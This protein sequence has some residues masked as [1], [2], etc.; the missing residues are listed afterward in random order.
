MGVRLLLAT[1]FACLFFAV[2]AQ[3]GSVR[4]Q[5]EC[6][7]CGGG[8]GLV[9]L[10][11]GDPGEANKI[12]V[13][14]APEGGAMLVT[15]TGTGATLTSASTNCTVTDRVARCEQPE[16]FYVFLYGEDGNDELS[17]DAISGSFSDYLYGGS[18]NDVLDTGDHSCC[19]GARLIGGP[20]DDTLHGGTGIYDEAV[21]SEREAPVDVSLAP[22]LPG[23]RNGVS[24]E[25][26]VLEP[27]MDGLW[28][29]KGND[30]L[31]GDED[32]NYIY[33]GDGTD[34]V[35][36][37][38]G[39][40][41]LWGDSWYDQGLDEVHGE[42]GD[43]RFYPGPKPGLIVGGPGT[44][45]VFLDNFA[46]AWFSRLSLDG[47][48]NDGGIMRSDS[49]GDARNVPA[50]NLLE[51]EDLHGNYAAD[52]L[53][54]DAGWNTLA[55]EG[56]SDIIKGAAGSDII[57]ADGYDRHGDDFVHALDGEE[58]FVDCGD[59][60][61]VVLADAIDDLADDCDQVSADD[62]PLPDLVLPDPPPP[63]VTP[64][65]PP[66]PPAVPAPPPLSPPFLGPVPG[67]R[68]PFRDAN[69]REVLT[70]VV[71]G[72][73][74]DECLLGSN[75]GDRMSGGG[76]SD[77]INGNRGNDRLRGGAGDDILDGG[78]GDD[79]L[80]GDAGKDRLTGGP[81]RDRLT[82]GRGNDFL[83]AAD[84]RRDVGVCGAGRDSAAVDR[85]D[86]VSGCEKVARTRKRGR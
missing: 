54:G 30:V 76:G 65:Y 17:T 71:T 3:A 83:I 46:P 5:Q 36:M 15:E 28:G 74:Y 52:V 68:P 43:D 58:D 50:G 67:P 27:D 51:V 12:A 29:G 61:D 8:G 55:G 85:Y 35:R 72:T 34:L 39:D 4:L 18:G 26:D 9:L 38:G 37:G 56:G 42:T 49:P 19:V 79:R 53:I 14:P 57:F 13:E 22:R 44:D 66:P 75:F 63:P 6:P 80:Y 31:T 81:G 33:T 70:P 73:R 41:I 62:L 21:Y 64:A 60:V 1:L 45:K 77:R 20:G 7:G 2:P 82:G 40:D 59:G 24:G 16:T 86:Q 69:C 10:W 11:K 32:D 25:R 48:A 47:Q 78:Q 23:A 84:G